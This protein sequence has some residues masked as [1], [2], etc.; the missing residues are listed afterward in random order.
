MV[1]CSKCTLQFFANLTNFYPR[2]QS[3]AIET[4][5]EAWVFIRSCLKSEFKMKTRFQQRKVQ[6][7]GLS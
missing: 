3:N 4:L 2:R 7:R 1:L 6:L 5:T